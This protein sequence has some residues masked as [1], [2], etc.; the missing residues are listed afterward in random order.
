MDVATWSVRDL[1]AALDRAGV[2]Y[3][4]VSEK[5]DLVEKVRAAE[6][7]DRARGVRRPAAPHAPPAA[8]A[9]GASAPGRA[10]PA[11]SDVARILRLSE[12]DLYGILD[13]KQSADKAT[14]KKAYRT[15]A[16]KLHPDKCHAPHADEA[17]KRVSAAFATLSNPLERA[18]HDYFGAPS[19]G[20][21]SGGG[22]PAGTPSAPRGPASGFGDTDAEEL[23]R[24]FFSRGGE[25][26]D[27]SS[28]VA[29][30]VKRITGVLAVGRRLGSTFSRNPWTLLTALSG[31]A[32]LV[33]VVDKLATKFGSSSLL[34]V[35]VVIGGIVAVPKEQRY[36]IG[37]VCAVVLC[38]GWL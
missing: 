9:A 13:V 7:A 15:L 34:F 1:K 24:A 33:N 37:A 3:H 20:G 8:A 31:L 6:V 32:S 16:L 10:A 23:F 11:Q 26:D 25:G 35:P 27:G 4:G 30:I 19:S 5:R 12:S 29:S 2:S 14:L 28:G 38:S 18:Q 17:F 21:S 22:A 36:T